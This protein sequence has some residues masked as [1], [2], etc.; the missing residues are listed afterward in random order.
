MRKRAL[1][2]RTLSWLCAALIVTSTSVLIALPA[3]AQGTISQTSPT[4]GTVDVAGSATF[5][6]PLTTSGSD[7][8]GVT[9]IGTS[10]PTGLVLQTVGSNTV[11]ATSGTLAANTY[12]ISGTDS[13]GSADAGTWTY[14]L[15]VAAD[16]ITQTSSTTGTVDVADSTSFTANL[17]PTTENGVA[18][19][20]AQGASGQSPDLTITSAGT[21][22][23]VGGPLAVDS[24]TISGTT[25]DSLNDAGTWTYTL[26]VT[27]GTITQTSP[28]TGTVDVASS[29]AFSGQLNPTTA[30]GESVAYTQGG[31]PQSSDL[32][33]TSGGRVSVL[34]GPLAVGAYTISG[35]TSNTEGDTGTWTYTLTVTGGTITQTS[36][37]GGTVDVVGS[38]AIS[39]QLNPT[40]ANGESVAYAQGASGQSPDLA[41]TSA[42]KVSVVGG[43]LAVGAY[44]ISGTTSNTEG[45]SG[46]WTY[47]L[48]VTA[49]TITQ[50]SPTSGS[51]SSVASGSYA[52]GSITVAHSV[53]AVTFVTT[54]TSPGLSV[55][56]GGLI[57]TTGSLVPGTY[58]VS[59]TDSDAKGDTG[60]WTYTLTVTAVGKSTIVQTS[61]TNGSTTTPNS[62]SFVPPS[63]TVTNNI[64]A[65][66]FATTTPSTGLKVTAAGVISVT[67]SLSAGTYTVSGTDSDTDGD[68]GSWTYTLTVTNIFETVTF[69]ANGGNG[70]MAPQTEDQPSQLTINTFAR[71]HYTFVDWN[72]AANGTGTGYANGVKYSFTS[73]LTLYAQWKAGKVPFHQVTFVA[74]GGSGS[75]AAESHNTATTL[76]PVHFT[77]ARYTFVGWNTKPN[78]SGASY[79]E[80]ATY[81][82]TSSITLFAQWKKIPPKPKPPTYTVTF[83]ANGGTGTMAAERGRAPAALDSLAFTRKGYAFT[84]WNTK[85]NGSGNDYA[86]RASYSF[87][88]SMTLYA[89]WHQVKVFVPPAIHAS[90]TIG[91]FAL[92]SSTLSSTLETQI[93]GLASEVKT[94]HDTS[95]ALVGF[96]DKLSKADELNEALWSAN[97][98]LSEN[99]A[100]AVESYLRGRLAAIGLASVS[101]TA[102]G[103]GS[104]IPGSSSSTKYSLVVASLT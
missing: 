79:A 27:G 51:T 80:G 90:G 45:D 6:A 103:S 33:I 40:T 7:G 63:L 8:N 62:S 20:Y 29:T 101:V 82:F 100:S 104:A 65:V 12:T 22:S 15:T 74:N 21:V 57:T 32:T 98:T 31:P 25:S 99:R 67:G 37:T 84:H 30:N 49:D 35:T 47:T 24:Y 76:T 70:S 102:T 36:P 72:T 23:V 87:S 61:T 13:D 69:D 46:T 14:T 4:T 64:G 83:V 26:T 59:G 9:F 19:A 38:T 52:P 73:P 86:N 34:G 66:T 97:Y 53:G 89:Q 44:T 88:A 3:S 71:S 43:P 75:M 78:G 93:G 92:K 77:R 91:P 17:N 85:P 28:T 94:Y 18:V 60:T 55:S 54:T 39:A 56:G 10:V 48:T 1:S 42:G 68:T 81:S 58:T 16:T 96:G 41:V 11:V 5:T 95:V 2:H 50:T